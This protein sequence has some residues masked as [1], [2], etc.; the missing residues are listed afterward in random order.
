MDNEESEAETTEH[1]SQADDETRVDASEE[2]IGCDVKT[3]H[4]G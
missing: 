3:E 1:V 2:T 4:T